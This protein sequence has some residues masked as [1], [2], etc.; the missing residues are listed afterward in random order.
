M[1]IN[2]RVRYAIRM[3]ADIAK[4]GGD[5]PVPLKDVADRQGLSKLYLS[6]LAT[7]LRN[8]SL[9]RSVWGNRGGYVLAR[10]P[11]QINLLDIMEAADG[12]VNVIDCVIEPD[13]CD[14]ADYCECIGVWRD[15]NNAIVQILEKY[16]L[17]DLI[18]HGLRVPAA[19]GAC[20]VA[21]TRGEPS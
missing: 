4:H 18:R 16:T 1:K 20:M 15:I 14:R 3:M 12:P 13:T 9:L 21:V 2:T 11:S 6:Q 10:P 17:E 5:E 7:A 8:A 19:G